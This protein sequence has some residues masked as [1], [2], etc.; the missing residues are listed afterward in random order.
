[1][2]TLSRLTVSTTAWQIV[3]DTV[4]PQPLVRLTTRTAGTEPLVDTTGR[5]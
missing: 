3:V 1:M 4:N 5:R 2:A